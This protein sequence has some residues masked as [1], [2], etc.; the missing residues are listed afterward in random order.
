MMRT[1]I[2]SAVAMAFM[3]RPKGY[4]EKK[5]GAE[6]RL[7]LR[8]PFTVGRVAEAATCATGVS[9]IRDC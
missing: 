5:S 9:A 7:L 2:K 8:G 3:Q 4:V 6:T 1:R